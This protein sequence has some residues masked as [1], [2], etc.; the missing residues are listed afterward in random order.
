MSEGE[1][2]VTFKVWLREVHFKHCIGRVGI[3]RVEKWGVFRGKENPPIYKRGL[4][5]IFSETS[6]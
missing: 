3:G 6:E 1:E 5:F 2:R 4:S